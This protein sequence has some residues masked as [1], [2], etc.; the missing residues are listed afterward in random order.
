MP[1]FSSEV[2]CSFESSIFV[3]LWPCKVKNRLPKCNGPMRL[4]LYCVL[5]LFEKEN[6]WQ[7]RKRRESRSQRQYLIFWWLNHIVFLMLYRDIIYSLEYSMFLVS[8]TKSCY[9][10]CES[11]SCYYLYEDNFL[12]QTE[13]LDNF[14]EAIVY[15]LGF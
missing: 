14:K 11:L 3:P 15:F 10:S 5:N 12:I 2:T 4:P 8:E 13:W 9:E 7:I 6:I 1:L